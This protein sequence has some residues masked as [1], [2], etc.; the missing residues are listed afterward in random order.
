MGDPT[1]R[2]PRPSRRRALLALGF[3]GLLGLTAGT[4]FAQ[5]RPRGG[6][7]RERRTEETPAGEKPAAPKESRPERPRPEEK[8]SVTHHSAQIGGAEVR[9]TATA[10]NLLLKEEDGT[11]KASIFIVAYTRDGVADLGRRPLTFAFNGGPGSASIWLHMGAFGPRRVLMDE[12]GMALPPPYQ[13]V[14]NDASLL[15]VTDLLSIHPVSSG[16]SRAVPGEDPKSFHG[17][18]G[19]VQSM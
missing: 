1:P 12:E 18:T 8:L 13:L 15:D 4:A 6:M 17:V 9:Y 7:E 16:F 19:D 11:P 5:P 10:G 2:E 14:D 3:A